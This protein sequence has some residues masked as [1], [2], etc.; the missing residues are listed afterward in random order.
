M[1]TKYYNDGTGIVIPASFGLSVATDPEGKT[2]S[3]KGHFNDDSNEYKFIYVPSTISSEKKFFW[4][5]LGFYFFPAKKAYRDELKFQWSPKI[6]SPPQQAISNDRSLMSN[7]TEV[8]INLELQWESKV[9]RHIFFPSPGNNVDISISST[10]QTTAPTQH[11]IE[12]PGVSE[13]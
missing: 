13:I 8:I 7:T 9:F 3:R 5:A 12:G 2:I 11:W 6:L 10:A 1:P 4:R